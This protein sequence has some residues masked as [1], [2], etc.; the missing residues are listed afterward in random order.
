MRDLPRRCVLIAASLTMTL[1]WLSA[2][3]STPAAADGQA[4]VAHA[5][6]SGTATEA[7]CRAQGGHWTRVGRIQKEVCAM[8]YPD[9][10]KA[11][12]DKADCT[13]ICKG[14]PDAGRNGT[15]ASGT[16]QRDD[17]DRFGCFA[18]IV[19]GTARPAICVD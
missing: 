7:S 1:S 14:E 18:E 19:N 2:C 17:H 8:P 15:P 10:G 4:P 11:C 9:A 5:Q 3:S 12:R 6:G 13:G 16:C